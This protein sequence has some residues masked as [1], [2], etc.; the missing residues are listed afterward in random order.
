MCYN[1]YMGQDRRGKPHHRR[2]KMI[3]LTNNTQI[4]TT[5]DT[6]Q[7]EIRVGTED[8]YVWTLKVAAA[9]S[10]NYAGKAADMKAA[11]DAYA[12]APV[13]EN[14]QQV[15]IDGKVYTAKYAR[16]PMQVSDPIEW[17]AA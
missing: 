8:G 7:P 12:A 11:A 1:R 16:K 5:A 6:Y 3:T 4:R 17:V 2:R 15:E 9:I 10:S 14:G 13:I